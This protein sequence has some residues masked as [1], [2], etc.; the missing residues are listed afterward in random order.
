[1]SELDVDF[2][3]A[4]ALV[5][6]KKNNNPGNISLRDIQVNAILR[7][8][9]LNNYK[10]KAA[11]AA[12]TEEDLDLQWKILV[13]DKKSTSIVSSILRVKDL[14]EAG[15]TVHTIIDA[16]RAS[17][18]DVP[19][20]Y[21]VSPTK[22]NLDLI[23][24]DLK[25]DYYSSF[26]INFN[27]TISRNLLEYFAKNVA[28]LNKGDKIKQLYDQYLDFLITEKN[29]FNLQLEKNFLQLNNP[30]SNEDLI[31]NLCDDIASGL[32]NILITT[33]S[34]P[35]IR[36]PLGGP[37]EL[38]ATKLNS[39]LRDYLINVKSS[40]N[41]S[42][43]NTNDINDIH[44]NDENSPL[45][46]SVLILLDRNIDFTSMFA[47]SWIYQ[48]MLFDIFNLKKN[49]ISIPNVSSNNEQ[50]NVTGSK[51]FDLDP[52]DFFWTQNAHLP[53]PEAAENVELA[54][55]NYKEKV[56]KITSKTGVQ[57]LNDLNDPSLDT[58][59]FQDAIKSLPELAFEKSVI[60]SHMNILASL[61]QQLQ[62]KNLDTFFEIEQF[63]LKNSKFKSS[64]LE[65]L[66]DNNLLNLSDKLRSF[67]VLY[68][69][70]KEDQS[71]S[72]IFNK[73][74]VDECENYFKENNVDISPL[75]YIYKI[76]ELSN[77]SLQNKTLT[78]TSTFNDNT[79][80]SL[81]NLYNL[82]EGKLQ[83]GVGSLISSLKKF[84]P[85][86]KTIPITNIVEAI[87][88]PL[89]SSNKNLSS[90][91]NYLYIDPNVI[92]GSHTKKPKRQTY[93][94]AFVFVIGGGNYFE[95]QNLQE[96]AHSE[97]DDNNQSNL[98]N[99]TIN[100][101]NF[102]NIDSNVNDLNFKKNVMYGST[103]IITP[104][105][106]LAEITELANIN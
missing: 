48:C 99:A 13:M 56:N 28:K 88:D 17:L 1:M 39:K 9:D 96:W 100:K 34:I 70:S 84:L 91:D 31:N 74:F 12:E 61:L 18:P 47:H 20:I 44:D 7:M 89:N 63:D 97:F 25:N 10:N 6:H 55:S 3:A 35:I 106:F 22:K 5:E 85:E 23:L 87:M 66:N 81:S 103:D 38:V 62:L 77:L 27:S 42:I 46:K 69:L 83:T 105:D 94:N 58:K 29:L 43:D 82:T 95:Y 86:K 64:F 60:D 102:S 2:S 24:E 33:N 75:S 14:L 90:T 21:F 104:D 73:S 98:N 76:T 19:A 52:N 101:N 36:A 16:N 32:F 80:S 49:I 8:L 40:H 72:N 92:R 78:A 59:N 15:I 67:I 68:L 51:S 65:I 45:K 93:N 30:K 54:L 57:D 26:F 11:S 4:N 41:S 50:T 37:A 79:S 71:T 53:F